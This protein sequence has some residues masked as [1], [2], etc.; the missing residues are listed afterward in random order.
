MDNSYA[1][2]RTIIGAGALAV[3]AGAL[4]TTAYTQDGS[5]KR[6]EHMPEDQDSWLEIP[7]TRHRLAFDTT[8]AGSAAAGMNF[9]ANYYLANATGY[10]INPKELG[11]VLILRAKSTPFA[12]NDSIWAKYHETFIDFL[13]LEGGLAER[14]KATNPLFTGGTPEWEGEE[15]RTLSEL[16]QKGALFAVCGLATEG[17]AG[18]LANGSSESASEIESDLKANLIPNARIVPAGIVAVNRVQEHGYAIAYVG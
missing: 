5:R 14:A 18:I 12:Y 16:Q 10:G 3:G 13:K 15:P 8:D 11:V 4:A 9:A 17:I 7:N 6:W 1:D 2:R